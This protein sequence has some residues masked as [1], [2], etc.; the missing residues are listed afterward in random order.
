VS[1]RKESPAIVNPKSRSTWRSWLKRNHQHNDSVLLVVQK[2]NS[3]EPGIKY[4]D[5]VEEALCFGW[6]DAKATSRDENSWFQI[7]SKR[8]KKSSW[9]AVN[10]KR[11]ASLNRRGLMERS[12]LDAVALAK[13]TG[14]WSAQDKVNKLEVPA[15]LKGA[16]KKN[17]TAFSNWEKFP[18]YAKKI[19]L[20]WI[21]SAKREE[22]RIK[23][24]HEVVRLAGL[25][26][27]AVLQK[28]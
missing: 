2:K 11:I 13:K 16:F 10:K 18:P 17:A 8:N 25:N 20:G 23:R 26:L 6:I 24:I 22:T 7:F 12:G 5:A 27:K 28:G 19:S 9:S 4:L 15:D 21:H 3:E 1:N 14:A